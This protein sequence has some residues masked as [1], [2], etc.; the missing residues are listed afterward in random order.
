[1]KRRDFLK[2]MTALAAGTVSAPAIFSPA[3]AQG[4]AGDAADRLGKRAQ[5][6]RHPR[7]RHQR[8]R[9]RSVVELLRPTHQPRDEDAAE[10][11]A[12]LRPR[13]VQ[14]RARRR[15]ER[16][17]HVGHLQAEEE[18]DLPGRHAG[19]RQGRQ[20][21]VRPRRHR[22]RLPDLPDGRGLAHQAGAVRGGRR[23]H[24]PRR[25]PAQGPAHHPRSRG[26][27]ALRHQFRAGEEATPPKRTRGASST[28]SRTPPAAAPTRSRAG[29]PAPKSSWSATTTGKAGRCRRSSA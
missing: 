24:H 23:Q 8:A 25:F 15:H 14:A 29:T 2:S 9:L 26:D 10:R 11:H 21:V 20:M 12:I 27:R 19:H 1:M 6:S 7:H 3:S 13:Q 28:P 18:R 4:R 5:Q 17:R 22:R 16:R